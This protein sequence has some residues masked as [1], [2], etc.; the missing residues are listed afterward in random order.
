MPRFAVAPLGLTTEVSTK[1]KLKGWK[2]YLKKLQC[3]KFKE[4]NQQAYT[5]NFLQMKRLWRVDFE[6]KYLCLIDFRENGPRPWP[7]FTC[8]RKSL[9][10]SARA[11]PT[12][13]PEIAVR[14]TASLLMHPSGK[15]R[16]FWGSSRGASAGALWSGGLWGGGAKRLM[17]PG[18]G[19][20]VSAWHTLSSHRLWRVVNPPPPL[21]HFPLQTHHPL[22]D[23]VNSRPRYVHQRRSGIYELI[24]GSRIQIYIGLKRSL[25]QTF[26][27][28]N[29]TYLL[30][31]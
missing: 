13:P 9:L 21:P 16:E 20:R 17:A 29:G 8:N 2:C 12:R 28:R 23:S 3:E 10:D 14:I 15:E 22:R 4:K 6:K 5:K 7:P 24:F 25:T 11:R 18:R 26:E 27:K 30:F 19:R 1:F 31:F